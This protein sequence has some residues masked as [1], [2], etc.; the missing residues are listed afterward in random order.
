MISLEV[1]GDEALTE[2]ETWSGSGIITRDSCN[3]GSCNMRSVHM[4]LSGGNDGGAG[5]ESTESC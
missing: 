5:D 1:Q 3:V 4:R 2:E